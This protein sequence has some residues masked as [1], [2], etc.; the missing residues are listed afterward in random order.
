MLDVELWGLWPGGHHVTSVVLH[1]VASMLALARL[2][3]APARSLVVAALFA[4]HPTRV[5]SVAWVSER[6]D[7]LCAVFW[8][9]TL[10]TYAAYV[11][12]PSRSRYW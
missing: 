10:A 5:E 9:A 3:G 1:A 12:A 11:K 6:K 4:L 7:V 8:F 2:T